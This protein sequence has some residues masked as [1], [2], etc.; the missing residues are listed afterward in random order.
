ME[1]EE[2]LRYTGKDGSRVEF[3]DREGEVVR[4][5]DLLFLCPFGSHLYGTED[6]E[7]DLDLKGIYAPP[8]EDVVLNKAD[9][10][11]RFTT[12]DSSDKTEEGDL[13]VELIDFRKFLSDAISGQTYAVELLHCP[14]DLRFVETDESRVFLDRQ[15]EKLL[16]DNVA[17]FVGYCRQQAEKYSIKGQRLSELKEVEEVMSAQA[18]KANVENILDQ[19]D[20]KDFEYVGIIEKELNDGETVELLRVA[21]KQYNFHSDIGSAYESVK[22]MI[23][24]YGGRSKRAAKDGIDWKATYHAYRVAFELRELLQT[25]E[26]QFPLDEAGFLHE[27]KKGEISP[28][29][30]EEEIPELVDGV[31]SMESEFSSEPDREF[32]D[33]FIVDYYKYK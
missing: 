29:R 31:T 22:K 21:Q 15:S 32:W 26:V 14:E 7:S 33:E 12:G 4:T 8:F 9:R 6:E 25:G 27:V 10:T 20:L 18:P 19:L 3:L 23:D 1:H 13:D 5:E 2:Y 28:S 24:K 17:P 16:S 30:A 11:V